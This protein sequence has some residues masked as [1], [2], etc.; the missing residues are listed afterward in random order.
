M[1][2]DRWINGYDGLF[3]AAEVEFE[4]VAVQLDVLR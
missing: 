4:G 2:N 1:L 3:D